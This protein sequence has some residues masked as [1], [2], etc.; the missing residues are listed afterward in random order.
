MGRTGV[1]ETCLMAKALPT[2]PEVPVMETITSAY[3]TGRWFLQ[4][5][6]RNAATGVL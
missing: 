4:A 3:R 2:Q 1:P 6:Q 5:K